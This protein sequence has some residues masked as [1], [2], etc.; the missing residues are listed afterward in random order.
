M[1]KPIGPKGPGFE[2]RVPRK[3]P[4]KEVLKCKEHVMEVAKK[5]HMHPFTGKL[6]QVTKQAFGS[7]KKVA[8]ALKNHF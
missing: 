3:Q 5:T 1:V 7:F 8:K 6:P 2:G 4:S